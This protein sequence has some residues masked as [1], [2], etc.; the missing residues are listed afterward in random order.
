MS[1]NVA[2]MFLP[3]GQRGGMI[4]ISENER[5]RAFGRWLRTGRLPS[6]QDPDSIE[7]KLNQWHDPENGR[8]TF[9]GAGRHYGQGGGGATGRVDWSAHSSRPKSQGSA[10]LATPEDP[11]RTASPSN[12]APSSKTRT[13]AHDFYLEEAIATDDPVRL[14]ELE[15]QRDA[16]D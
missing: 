6:V 4:D 9:V 8:F 12:R 14:A 10:S 5:W 11:T 13:I 15:A 16:E 3:H 1:E 7:L 2:Q